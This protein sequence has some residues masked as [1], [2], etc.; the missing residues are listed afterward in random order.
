MKKFP[1]PFLRDLEKSAPSAA[2]RV[3][4]ARR[5][6]ENNDFFKKDFEGLKDEYRWANY[7]LSD[8]KAYQLTIIK[9]LTE[10]KAY[11]AEI[12]YML[13][14]G[15]K[16][17]SQG[18]VGSDLSYLLQYL[19]ILCDLSELPDGKEFL[20]QHLKLL[21]KSSALRGFLIVGPRAS[22]LRSPY[23]TDRLTKLLKAID[24]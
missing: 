1:D 15:I 22:F 3:E 24:L 18:F 5:L 13:N 10:A 12:N 4:K 9:T 20:K 16:N 11:L 7:P 17:F 2:W 14:Q 8:A 19:D 23:Y 21:G 6:A